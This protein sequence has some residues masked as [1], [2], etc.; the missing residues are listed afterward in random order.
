MEPGTYCLII[1]NPLLEMPVGALG[2]CVFPAG[3]HVYV[4]SALGPG[5]LIRAERH[6]R[7]YNLK[8]RPPRWHIDYLLLH[9]LCRLEAVARIPSRTRAECMLAGRIPG[10]P[11][12]GFGS[13]DCDCMSHL[14]SF[15][16][17]PVDAVQNA[18]DHLCHRVFITM[19]DYRGG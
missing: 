13:S 10:K 8:N 9:P 7:L 6:I 1:R 17:F 14:F 19:L 18:C 4:G 5:G 11:V 15:P 16:V 2:D 3:W 12:P